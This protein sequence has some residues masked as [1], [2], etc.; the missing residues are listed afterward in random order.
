MHKDLKGDPSEKLKYQ[1]SLSMRKKGSN[2]EILLFS[3]CT[4]LFKLEEPVDA[5]PKVSNVAR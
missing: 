5:D 2:K 1:Q 4:V 3:R